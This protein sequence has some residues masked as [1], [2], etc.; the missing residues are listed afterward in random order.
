MD[1]GTTAG[2]HKRIQ[3]NI[4]AE[5]GTHAWVRTTA[6]AAFIVAVSAFADT[7]PVLTAHDEQHETPFALSTPLPRCAGSWTER[8]S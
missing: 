8:A 2:Q 6:V 5:Q 7:L 1:W 3:R 4:Q